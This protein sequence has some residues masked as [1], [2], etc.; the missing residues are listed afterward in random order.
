MF[1]TD[2]TGAGLGKENTDEMP[3]PVLT[4]AVLGKRLKKWEMA[5]NCTSL[6]TSLDWVQPSAQHTGSSHSASGIFWK[7]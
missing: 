7:F 2:A 4:R 1:N 6:H 5:G 3:G